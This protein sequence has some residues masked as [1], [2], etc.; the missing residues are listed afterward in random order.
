VT[1]IARAV[2]IAGAYGVAGVW[3][4][5]AWIGGMALKLKDRIT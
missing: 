1:G 4:G 5:A 3:F 2:V